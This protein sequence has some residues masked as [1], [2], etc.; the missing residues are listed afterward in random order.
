MNKTEILKRF[1]PQTKTVEIKAW[2]TSV[3]IR[4]L[5]AKEFGEIQSIIMDN[6]VD[7]NVIDGK[8][9]V[10]I[11]DAEKGKFTR[12]SMALVKPKLSVEELESLGESALPGINEINEA[13]GSFNAPK[14]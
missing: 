8:V 1:K 4:E 14:K 10:S 13:I 2:D 9:T 7:E 11:R 5:S 3:E 12:V 6:A